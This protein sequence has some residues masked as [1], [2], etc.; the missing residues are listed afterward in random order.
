[1]STAPL[2]RDKQIELMKNAST[3][4]DSRV[5][6]WKASATISEVLRKPHHALSGGGDY[7][8]RDE[9]VSRCG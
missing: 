2:N 3:R 6:K 5:E 9:R 7:A 8:R 1:M 4:L